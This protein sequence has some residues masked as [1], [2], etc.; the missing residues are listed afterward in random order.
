MGWVVAIAVGVGWGW[1]LDPLHGMGLDG[2]WASLPLLAVPVVGLTCSRRRGTRMLLG[3]TVLTVGVAT[4]SILLEALPH[5]FAFDMQAKAAQAA[6][7][8]APADP[9]ADRT[10]R[11]ATPE[12]VGGFAAKLPDPETIRAFLQEQ[13]ALRRWLYGRNPM[14]PEITEQEVQSLRA[15]GGQLWVSIREF[16]FSK[17]QSPYRR[18]LYGERL[19]MQGAQVEPTVLRAAAWSRFGM[20]RL[21]LFLVAAA[22][23]LAMLSRPTQSL[24]RS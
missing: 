22:V 13:Q 18:E 23:G 14:P 1:S 2:V 16:P 19:Y 21:I 24:H 10:E 8:L 3:A 9:D 6:K 12:G 5:R 15:N 7:R 4:G 17:G 11:E 20:E